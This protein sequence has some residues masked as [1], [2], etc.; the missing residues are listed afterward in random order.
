MNFTLLGRPVADKTKKPV[1]IRMVCLHTHGRI[2]LVRFMSDDGL[3]VAAYL[4]YLFA[5]FKCTSRNV[6]MRL[7]I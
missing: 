2:L 7:Y 4:V 6:S 1:G 3:L 5:G